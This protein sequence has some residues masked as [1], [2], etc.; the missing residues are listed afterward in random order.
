MGLSPLSETSLNGQCFK[1][2]CT[3]W[4]EYFRPMSLFASNTVFAGFDVICAF[5]ASPIR[6]CV[7]VNATTEGVV[8]FP[9]SLGI[10]STLSSFHT[11]TQEYLRKLTI[12]QWKVR[13]SQI[14]TNTIS[15]YVLIEYSVKIPS[16]IMWDIIQIVWISNLIR[17]PNLP[18]ILQFLFSPNPVF[19]HDSFWKHTYSL[20]SMFSRYYKPIALSLKGVRTYYGKMFPDRTLKSDNGILLLITRFVQ[21]FHRHGDRTPLHNYFAGTPQ[22]QD[23]VQLWKQYVFHRI[24]LL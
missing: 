5:A 20:L 21:V 17:R 10:I 24:G 13:C 23:E 8:R 14:D 16:F 1:S 7:S 22:E 4:S 9:I 15:L 12:E 3:I 2:L 6:R 19:P 18:E 11:P